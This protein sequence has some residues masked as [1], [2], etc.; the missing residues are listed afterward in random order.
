M[1]FDRAVQDAA[2][3]LLLGGFGAMWQFTLF[4]ANSFGLIFFLFF[5]FQARSNS[6][7]ISRSRFR[8]VW[9]KGTIGLASPSSNALQAHHI[10]SCAGLSQG[11]LHLFFLPLTAPQVAMSSFAF[12]DLHDV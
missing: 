12:P 11:F 1:R 5:L 9:S 10:L 6:S 7:K 3:A 2:T 4:K 8:C